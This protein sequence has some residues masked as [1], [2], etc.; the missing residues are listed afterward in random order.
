M[1]RNVKTE[2]DI[3]EAEFNLNFIDVILICYTLRDI[4]E[5]RAFPS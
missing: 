3:K 2:V 5:N 4:G 1:Q